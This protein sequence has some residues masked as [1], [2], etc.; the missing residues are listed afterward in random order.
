MATNEPDG[1]SIAYPSCCCRRLDDLLADVPALDGGVPS[2][3]R[4]QGER[5]RLLLERSTKGPSPIGLAAGRHELEIVVPISDAARRPGRRALRARARTYPR[6][7]QACAKPPRAPV[8]TRALVARN[9]AASQVAP[10]AGEAPG[11]GTGGKAPAQGEAWAVDRHQPRDD[12]ATGVLYEALA[13]GLGNLVPA[14][15]LAGL[16]VHHELGHVVSPGPAQRQRGSASAR[17]R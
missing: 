6:T 7:L 16:V 17:P 12:G 4:A 11:W 13:V 1:R 15:A 9:L 2:E 5:P 10:A 3:V 8:G 14:E